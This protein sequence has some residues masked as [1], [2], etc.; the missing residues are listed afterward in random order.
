M[1]TGTMLDLINP[2]QIE[3]WRARFGPLLPRFCEFGIMA[4][5][6]TNCRYLVLG[7]FLTS[8]FWL[9]LVSEP[10]LHTSQHSGCWMGV[11]LKLVGLL[12]EWDPSETL[13]VK[14]LQV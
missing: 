2:A 6:R 5:S 11:G 10:Y 7:D 4:C 12:W 1:G 3:P 14:W 8:T 13:V 9:R